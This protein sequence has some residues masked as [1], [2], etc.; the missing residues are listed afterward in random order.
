MASSSYTAGVVLALAFFP[1]MA[2]LPLVLALY[3]Q[4]GLGYT[5]LESGLCLLRKGNAGSNTAADHIAVVR[6]ALTQ[7][8]G[9]KSGTRPGRKILIRAD[10]AGCT[11]EFLNWLVSQRLSYS[12]GFRSPSDTARRSPRG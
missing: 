6:A 3:Y 8:P 9:H 7:L 12:V 4:Q 5:A 2:G 1:A 10:G 11:H